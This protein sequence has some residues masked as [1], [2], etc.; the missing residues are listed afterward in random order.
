MLFSSENFAR[1]S[2][3]Q[4]PIYV[5]DGKALKTKTFSQIGISGK[6]RKT[7]NSRTIGKSV[8]DEEAPRILR[9]EVNEGV[10]L[11]KKV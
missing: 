3:K 5:V 9:S 2:K 4:N 7:D 1:F 8:F 10:L 6:Q 11:V